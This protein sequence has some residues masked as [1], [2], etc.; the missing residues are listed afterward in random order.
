[1][2]TLAVLSPMAAHAATPPTTDSPDQNEATIEVVQSW[3]LTPVGG[4]DSNGASARP[5]LSYEL[6]P[7]AVQQDAVT[8]FNFGNVQMD[9][10][11]YATDAFTTTDGQFSALAGDQQPVD[12]GSWVDLAQERVTV[13]PGKQ[14]T[15]PFTITVPPDANPGDHAGAIL[16]SSS[17]DDPT[18]PSDEVVIDRRTGTRLYLRVAGDLRPEL[19][20]TSVEA[21]YDQRFL[22][23]FGGTMSVTY[24]VENRGNVRMGG[25][26]VLEVVGPL[27]LS[28]RT[29]ELPDVPDLLPGETITVA[30][31][32]D[33][34]PAVLRLNAT[35]TLS[36]RLDGA[37]VGEASS[38]SD[39]AFAPPV[40]LL[41][42]ILVLIVALLVFRAA[43]RTS[44]SS[45]PGR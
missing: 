16:A 44:A 42:V 25:K 15:I 18:S 43:R 40:L 32:I 4:I 5:D 31:D 7:G 23:P 39:V 8:L 27:G 22:N 20:V 14:V 29:V 17:T 30:K 12:V 21:E 26:A 37:P 3:A 34:V 13:A 9:F 38:R 36:P 2:L 35:V 11:V 19:T 28:E 24:R 1:M 10:R 41:A 6:Q 33:G 45:S